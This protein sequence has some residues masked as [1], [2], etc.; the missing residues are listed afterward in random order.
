[1]VKFLDYNSL[2]NMEF[3]VTGA[4]VFTLDPCHIYMENIY[5]DT[6]DLVNG[7]GFKLG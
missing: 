4:I 5:A 1:L 3:Y 2:E 6:W 7:F